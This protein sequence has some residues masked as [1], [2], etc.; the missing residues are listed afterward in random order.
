VR[1]PKPRQQATHA[2]VSRRSRIGLNAINFF[3]AE[4]VGVV[5]PLIG[6][7]LKE[8]HWRYDSIGIAT[9][10][11][12]LGTLLVQ[13]S[14][15]ILTDRISSRRLLFAVAA[16][17]TGICFAAIPLLS[18]TPGSVDAFLFI[19][20]A[21]QSFF[22]PLLGALALAL[23]GH[24]LLNHTAGVNQGWNHAGNIV[25]AAAAIGLVRLLGVSAVFYA[26]GASSLLAAGSV[27]LIRT[28]DLDEHLATGLTQNQSTMVSWT[29]LIRER[30]VLFLFVSIFLFHLANAPILPTVALYVKQLGGSDDLM[31]ATVLTAQLVMVPVALLAGRYADR[32][33]RKPVMALAFWVLPFRI[34]SYSFVISPKAVVW[35]QGLDGIGAG[36]YGVVVIALAADLTQGKGR[37]NSL[38]GLFATALAVGGVAGPLA[39]GVLVQHL[40]F[41]ATFY[42][43]AALAVLGA[44]VFTKFV[45]E[46]KREAPQI[47]EPEPCR[48]ELLSA[49]VDV[50]RV[51]A[52][53]RTDAEGDCA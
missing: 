2:P 23:V 15:G 14:A 12:G 32:W 39:S 36:I 48:T 42:A 53:V 11:A 19:S 44:I 46:T 17:V 29:E 4:M 47:T 28:N 16:I 51:E 40:G 26:V 25:A 13:T 27:F 41:K 22:P 6:V 18:G 50:R 8:H 31:T 30:A 38:A 52:K 20:G 43:F 10:A 33:G 5:L 45:P 9:A 24:E 7:F 34:L 3:Q 1:Q 49:A 37:F 21:A 35:L